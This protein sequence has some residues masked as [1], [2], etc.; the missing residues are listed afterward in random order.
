MSLDQKISEFFKRIEG[1]E[2]KVER[3]EKENLFLRRKVVTLEDDLEK[4]KSSK[5]KKTSHNSSISPSQDQ[6]RVKP[7]Q[8]LRKKLG[9]KPGGQKGHKGNTLKMS[10]K[11]DFINDHKNT[12]CTGCGNKLSTEQRYVDCRQV[13]D[14]PPIVP[15]VTEHR[16][17]ESTCSCGK[18]NRAKYPPEATSQ[19]SY[20]NSIESLIGYLSVRQ[21]LPMERM[22]ELLD[23]VFNLKLSQGT[24]S[25][26]LKSLAK[27]CEPAYELIKS[28]IAVSPVVGADETGCVVNG[29]KHWVWTWQNNKMT[30][31][32]VSDTR[33]YRAIT[34]QFPNGLPESILISDCWA[35][36]LKTPSK[37]KQICLAHIQRELKYF[38]ESCKNRWSRK[39]LNLIY[40]ALALKKKL[41]SEPAKKLYSEIHK[42][43]DQSTIL[44]NQKVKGP[45]KLQ[46]LKNRLSKNADSLWVFLH[47]INV[48]PDNNGSER[49]IRNVKV[50]QKISGQFRSAKGAIQF[51]T[52]RS[53]LD[54]VNKNNGK[55]F[56][57]LDFLSAFRAE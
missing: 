12:C 5:L 18:L 35:A 56:H 23:Q 7:N 43:I 48:P 31:I 36:Q 49:A 45:P 52:I 42:I 28:K 29:L 20:G 21:Y 55:L 10:E 39:F 1:L 6:N 4:A 17:Y 51:A 14:I 22:A 16:I 32:S 50:K 38:I 25:N 9:R 54:T 3:L 41:I 11:I 53:V 44:L 2:K 47:Y 27:K 15:V 40:K 30:Y 33:G 19:I 13:I 8:S 37:S 26:K 57:T 24:I 34:D 46:T